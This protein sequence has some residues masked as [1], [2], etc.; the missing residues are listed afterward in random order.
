VFH[1]DPTANTCQAAP[2]T[3]ASG[4]IPWN[5]DRTEIL[6]DGIVHGTG[7][8]LGL[9][10]TIAILAMAIELK[11]IELGPT[12]IYSLGL[13][14]MLGVSAAYNMWP[15]SPTKWLLRRLDHSA[16]YLLVAATYM[17]FMSLLKNGL[18]W[19]VLM[20]AIW[21]SALAG[22]VLK[23]AMPGRF[24]RLSIVLYLSMGWSGL[25]AYKYFVVVLPGIAL[26]LLLTGGIFYSL[27]TVFHL[28]EN[29][30]FQNVIWHGFVLIAAICH[31]SA[32]LT[33]LA[34]T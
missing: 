23:L 13:L 31:Y 11:P 17:P 27:G 28:W 29:L 3:L 34:G 25:L 21:T 4:Q 18:V 15:V 6:A 1:R 32:V 26:W 2:A 10:G 5:Y 22:M 12:A 33:C 8:V 7:V 9:A 24:D 16:I 19:A 30:R 14:A 20:S